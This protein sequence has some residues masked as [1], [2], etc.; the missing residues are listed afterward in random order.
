MRTIK[1]KSNYYVYIVR[2]KQGMLY[3][4]YTSNLKVRIKRHNS[5]HGAKYLRGKGPVKLVWSKEYRY[6][7]CAVKEE[8]RIKRLPRRQKLRLIKGLARGQKGEG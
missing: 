3:A 7:K 2:C 4:G 1:R 5:G 8:A 6:W